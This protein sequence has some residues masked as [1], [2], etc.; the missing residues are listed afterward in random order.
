M[1]NILDVEKDST[2]QHISFSKQEWISWFGLDFV[3]QQNDSYIL[4]A[5]T[6]RWK[7]AHF[8]QI[9]TE[10]CILL[11]Q[12]LLFFSIGIGFVF[13]KEKIAPRSLNYHY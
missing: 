5:S 1:T 3:Q 11:F 9:L 7:N 10:S 12:P 8:G 4:V 2:N 6:Q 13:V